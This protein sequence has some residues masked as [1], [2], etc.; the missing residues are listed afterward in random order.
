MLIEIAVGVLGWYYHIAAIGRQF[1]ERRVGQDC[2]RAPLFAP[3]LFA[4][5]AVLSMLGLW[6][7]L[8]R[9][10]PQG[11]PARKL[12]RA[13]Q[14]HVTVHRAGEG[15]QV[16]VFGLRR[17]CKSRRLAEKWTSPR[18]PCERLRRRHIMPGKTDSKANRHYSF[19]FPWQRIPC[20]E[21]SFCTP[22][23]CD[24]SLASACAPLAP[25][26]KSDEQ[27]LEGVFLALLILLLFSSRAVGR[28]GGGGGGGSR[29]GERGSFGRSGEGE[30]RSD[31]GE[32]RGDEGEYRRSDEGE[33]RRGGEGEY[34]RGNEGEYRR[35]GEG[36]SRFDSGRGFFGRGGN[37]GLPGGG[38][39]NRPADNP[40]RPNALDRPY[41]SLN[42]GENWHNGPAPNPTP[43]PGPAPE[44]HPWLH[45]APN[46][47]PG[48]GPAPEP[49]PW[50]H[51]APNP[52]PG[53]GPEPHRWPPHPAPNPNPGP[54]PGPRSAPVAAASRSES[55]PGS[56]SGAG[57]QPELV[58]REL[59]QQLEQWLEQRLGRMARARGAPASQ[60]G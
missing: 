34:R 6:G 32:S 28:G 42:P 2:L 47:T 20:P 9:R 46:P 11:G 19:R 22:W 21:K 17:T 43:G 37:G 35:G 7:L 25:R 60:R 59:A 12:P 27:R 36:E 56:G 14:A 18:P 3:L 57:P 15:G 41:P 24:L 58:S 4:D 8:R 50:L 1:H 48:P 13:W 29:G 5:L 10:H 53:P 40:S 31:E 30:S 39:M 23:V 26:E 44:P 54:G 16:H 45:P 49:H 38:G 55:E 51:P 33:Y 52:T